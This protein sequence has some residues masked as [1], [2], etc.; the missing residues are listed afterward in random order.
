MSSLRFAVLYNQDEV[1]NAAVEFSGPGV[2]S[3]SMDA[4]FTISNM[5]TEWGPLVGWFP[6]DDITIAY[7]ERVHQQLAEQGAERLH[8]CRH[9]EVACAIRR[10]PIRALL[11]SPYHA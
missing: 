11:C 8:A 9:S 3:L 6:C 7:L 1:L 4:R 2:S 10:S 5:S